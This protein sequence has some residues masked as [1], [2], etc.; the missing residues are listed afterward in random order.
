LRKTLLLRFRNRFQTS[1]EFDGA[2]RGDESVDLIRTGRQTILLLLRAV[3]SRS[4]VSKPKAWVVVELQRTLSWR[5]V[6]CR[7]RRLLSSAVL[8]SGDDDLEGRIDQ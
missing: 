4:K 2:K 5:G 8:R 7:A 6:M 1:I 3:Y